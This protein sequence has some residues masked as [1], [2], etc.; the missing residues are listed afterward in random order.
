MIWKHHYSLLVSAGVF[1][2]MWATRPDFEEWHLLPSF[3]LWG[4]GHAIIVKL[5]R[6]QMSPE[7]AELKDRLE[8]DKMRKE[9]ERKMRYSWVERH[10]GALLLLFI[11]GALFVVGSL[12]WLGTYGIEGVREWLALLGCEC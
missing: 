6:R 3:G 4:G 2:A 9:H 12:L 10:E 1:V 11:G 5:G 7:T 8:R